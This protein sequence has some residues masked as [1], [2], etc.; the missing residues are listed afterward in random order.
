MKRHYFL[1][2]GILMLLKIINYE[3]NPLKILLRIL[4][5][6]PEEEFSLMPP[7]F[8]CDN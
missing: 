2:K 7:R 5:H 3:I 1:Q 4:H 6:H 8:Q